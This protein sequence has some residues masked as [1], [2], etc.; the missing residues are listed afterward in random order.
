MISKIIAASIDHN[1]RDGVR[2]PLECRPTGERLVWHAQ[3]D[4]G[5]WY[6][7]DV[8]SDIGAGADGA[9]QAARAAWGTPGWNLR[10][11]ARRAGA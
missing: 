1:D 2:V 10:F 11:H 5:E 9:K 6:S 7:T 8:D 4:E 3:D